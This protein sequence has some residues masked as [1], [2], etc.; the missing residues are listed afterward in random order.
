MRRISVTLAAAAVLC[1]L[2][3]GLCACS[4]LPGGGS[5]PKLGQAI[6]GTNLVIKVK[7]VRFARQVTGFYPAVKQPAKAFL[8]AFVDVPA[9]AKL[10][11]MT[12]MPRIGPPVVFALR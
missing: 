3:A 8:W 12:R 1:A 2:A 9:S 11:L 4:L 5:G 6:K 10:T 7:G